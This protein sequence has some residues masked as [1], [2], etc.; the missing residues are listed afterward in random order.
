VRGWLPVWLTVALV[1]LVTAPASYPGITLLL[2]QPAPIAPAGRLAPVDPLDV[3]WVYVRSAGAT[4]NG[5][6]DDT[7]AMEAALSAAVQQGR[8]VFCKAGTYLVSSTLLVG[9]D[10]IG[11]PSVGRA[12]CIIKYVGRGPAMKVT[13]NPVQ[14][15]NVR[16]DLTEDSYTGTGGIL[17]P[18]ACAHCV[19]SSITVNGP[20]NTAIPYVNYGILLAGGGSQD[21]F[22]NISTDFATSAI[23]A[24][25]GENRFYQSTFDNV[26]A[27]HCGQTAG[28]ACLQVTGAVDTIMNSG[29]GGGEGLGAATR[30]AVLIAGSDAEAIDIIATEL[31]PN[32][33]HG[34]AIV[35]M[36]PP[37]DVSV[38]T[39]IDVR[40]PVP[41]RLVSDVVTPPR[42]TRIASQESGT[43]PVGFISVAAPFAAFT[44]APDSGIT[45]ERCTCT[46]VAGTV[47]FTTGA[48]APSG[49]APFAAIRFRRV[50]SAA[51]IVL[52]SGN[53]EPAAGAGLYVD[54]TSTETASLRSSGLRPRTRYVFSYHVIER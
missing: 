25:L 38:V 17:L 47:A 46:A 20:P 29:L 6:T 42:V 3:P 39:L 34:T 7:A 36:R 11:S 18:K 41:A 4:G 5:V 49:A 15:H 51:P 48:A 21:R 23:I 26:L 9:T 10:F 40:L 1:L 37:H 28:R 2:G 13:A 16:L 33:P 32:A 22:A 19:F 53:S 50:Y 44:P 14:I 52:L 30:T 31:L 27:H 43:G 54:A 12:A 45:L 8:P 24:G 35:I